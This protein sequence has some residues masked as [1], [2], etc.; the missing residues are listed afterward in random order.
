MLKAQFISAYVSCLLQEWENA[1]KSQVNIDHCNTYY[2]IGIC[3]N[4]YGPKNLW[5]YHSPNQAGKTP[6]PV[7]RMSFVYSCD[8]NE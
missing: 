3:K 1:K 6:Q 5:K 4:A 7:N 8:T 2:K